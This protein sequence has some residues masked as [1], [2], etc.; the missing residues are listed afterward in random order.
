MHGDASGADTNID[1][2]QVDVRAGAANIAMLAPKSRWLFPR[3]L[4]AFLLGG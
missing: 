2:D 1:L 4:A 3:L